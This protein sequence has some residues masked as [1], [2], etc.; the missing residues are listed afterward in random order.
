MTKFPPSLVK[1]RWT[2]EGSVSEK[3]ESPIDGKSVQIAR[4]GELMSMCA[5]VCHI[6]SNSEEGYDGVKDVVSRLTIESRTL[7]QP[8]DTDPK[9]PES[10]IDSSTGL[11]R[12]VI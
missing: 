12:N 4:Y 2:K 1:K 9:D 7:P 3:S 11:H 8:T 10:G 6:A 5:R